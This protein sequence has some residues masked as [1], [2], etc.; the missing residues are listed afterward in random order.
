[1]SRVAL[2]V[3]NQFYME[4]KCY[5]RKL[6]RTVLKKDGLRMISLSGND[7]LKKLNP[8][9]TSAV[10]DVQDDYLEINGQ[11]LIEI[12]TFLKET[13]ELSFNYLSFI[14]GV[15]YPEHIELLYHLVSFKHLHSINIKVLC[16][17][18]ETPTIASVTE[19]W[20]G[21]DF[22]ERE[23]YDLMGVVF[24]GHPKLKR[25]LLWEGFKGYPLRK[26]YENVN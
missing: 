26:D 18:K 16:K 21:A 14:T 20:Q 2:R 1:M 7:L 19:I 12:A 23:I 17:N 22:Q 11:S 9:L 13:P 4:L 3:R 8:E 5:I 24:I 10:I 25:I 15:D 6:K